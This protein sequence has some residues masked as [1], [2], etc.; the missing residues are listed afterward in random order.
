MVYGKQILT[1]EH[2]MKKFLT[3][4]ALILTLTIIFL[5]CSEE[6]DH[7]SPFDPE[8]WDSDIPSLSDFNLENT[9]I[10]TIKLSWTNTAELPERYSYRI[11]KKVGEG[12][13]VVNYKIVASNQTTCKD[14][15]EINK[16]ISYRAYIIYDKNTSDN[17][18]SSIDNTFPAPTNLIATPT[19][20]TST[21]LSWADNSIGEEKFIIERKLST[22][23]NYAKIDS[24]SGSNIAEKS[25]IDNNLQP[26]LIYDYKI[27]AIK[28]IYSSLYLSKTFSNTFY[29]PSDL[30]IIQNNVFTFTLDWTDNSN[31]E[32]GFKVERKIDYGEFTEIATVTG[33]NY[34]D[35]SVLKKGYGIVYY[36]VRAFKGTDYSSYS[37]NNSAVLFP[38]PTNLEVTQVSITSAN[39]TW[40]DNSIG[41]EKFEI[42][43]KL[44]TESTY[45]KVSEVTGSNTATK[46][47]IDTATISNLTFDYRLRAIK[48]IN[49]TAFITRSLE[50][51]FP[52]PTNLSVT[53]TSVINATIAWTDNSIGEDR[54]E[55]GRKLSTESSYIKIAE[56]TGSD[57]T[58][59]SWNDLT[60]EP[61]N[62]YDYR[63]S[64][65]KETYNS[66]YI[67]LT[68]FANTFPPP[69]NL[70]YKKDNIYTINLNWSEIC[71]G[72]DGFKID[73]KTGTGDWITGF[74]TVSENAISWSDT[75][76]E[77]N[78]TIEYRVYAFKEV[79]STSSIYTSVI[80]N[81]FPAPTNISSVVDSETSIT[82]TWTDNSNG[83]QEFKID[84]MVGSTGTWMT[85]YVSVAENISTW[86]DTGLTTGTTYYYKIRANYSSYYSS[87]TNETYATPSP[88]LCMIYIPIGSFSMGLDGGITNPVHTVNI[89]RPYYL[90]KYELTQKE[91][92]TIMES[93]VANQT[94]DGDYLPM[95][96][97]FSWYSILKYCNLRS[98]AEGL[99]PCYSISGSTDPSIW[100]PVPTSA[101]TAWNA[102][103]CN[104]NANG[105]RLPSEA[106]W[107]YA[108]RYNDGRSYP[109]G[110]TLPDSALCNYN[111]NVGTATVVGSY[112][113]GNSS[114][115]L[116]DMAGNAQEWV[117]DKFEIY[118]TT[119]QTDPIGPSSTLFNYRVIRGGNWSSATDD[120]NSADRYSYY[121]DYITNCGF[122]LA[123]TKL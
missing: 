93:P 61:E 8:Y 69:T 67:T 103:G 77:I 111:S 53:Q 90:S 86:T 68:G 65:I 112:P 84:R 25:W 44:S 38:P 4:S 108:A 122:R 85:D 95:T 31:G 48:G 70:Q 81:T 19:S 96:Y 6:R 121:P 3:L 120:I 100:G 59:K 64:G 88:S 78:Q 50:N 73:K 72:E 62:I 9:A 82:L 56:V 18:E 30:T 27:K 91:W 14:Y 49:N 36:Q 37:T 43:R 115:G 89:T 118:P 20:I 29:A 104:F 32:D 80:D 33:T 12:N 28:G 7:A 114:L 63:V 92:F 1:A 15:V 24:V 60:V 41:E 11:D 87:Y 22:E 34:I 23:V 47:W 58:T 26:N 99:T 109:W 35:N 46:S 39:L 117:W 71:N 113:I 102:A 5:A 116:C 101:S 107:E 97:S 16:N 66:S 75:N 105:Y 57:T 119:T 45:V 79:F 2:K 76:A 74:A 123:R 94:K 52:A 10:D 98:L 13:W 21:T 42:E 40:T 106:E 55:I 110:N 54:F 51:T 83:E 17:K